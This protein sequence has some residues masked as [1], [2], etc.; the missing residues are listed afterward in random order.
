MGFMQMLLGSANFERLGFRTIGQR[1][2]E[3]DVAQGSKMLFAL[4][5]QEVFFF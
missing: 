5:R 1:A 3:G 2:L 4:T